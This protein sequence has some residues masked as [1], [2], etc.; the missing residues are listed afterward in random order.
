M[1]DITLTAGIRANLSSLQK[2]SK[3]MESTQERLATGKKVNSAVDNP[4]NFFVAANLNDRATQLEARIDGMGQAVSVLQTSDNTITSM[5]S[6][7]SA[8]KGVVDS[9]L[10]S[11]D[12]T[13]RVSLGIQYNELLI[14][15]NDMAED[16]VYQGVNL[17]VSNQSDKT[18]G[19]T[20]TLTVQFNER[21]DD[22]TLNIKGVN[23]GSPTGAG[24]QGMEL[25]VNGELNN[26]S[27]VTGSRSTDGGNNFVSQEY[28][29]TINFR[30]SNITA[31]GTGTANQ[32][33]VGLRSA[34]VTGAASAE[35]NVNGTGFSISFVDP[36]SYQANLK[37]LASD[38]ESF[39]LALLSTSKS[40]SQSINIVS[41]RQEFTT[42][43]I[44][45]LQT[46][47]DKLTLADLNEEGANLLSLQ[48]SQ[49]LGVQSLTLASQANQSVLSILG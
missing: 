24:T 49:Q 46:G 1:A 19:G 17:L 23:V 31:N 28:A 6:L 43:L 12:S 48:T 14:Q 11:T 44:N 34:D 2:T 10:S 39:D 42:E 30:D 32:A 18:S 47:A 27:Y 7:I 40:L 20:E 15:L 8:M 33:V 36:D 5:R 35:Q 4:K 3:L 37:S 9:A 25:D 38:V 29:L 22:S 41:I 26:P 45:T 21:F 13:D 16:A